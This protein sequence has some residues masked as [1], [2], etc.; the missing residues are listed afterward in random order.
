MHKGACALEL[1]HHQQLARHATF[2]SCVHSQRVGA[3]LHLRQAPAGNLRNAEEVNDSCSSIADIPSRVLRKA[4]Q[5]LRSRGFFCLP[6]Q[7]VLFVKC[8][9]THVFNR[10]RAS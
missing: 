8:G 6:R 4:F 7:K 9:Q 3:G 2:G 10:L 5:S 1:Q